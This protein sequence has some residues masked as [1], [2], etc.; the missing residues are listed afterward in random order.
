[1]VELQVNGQIMGFDDVVTLPCP[2]MLPAPT[3][4]LAGQSRL[5]QNCCSGFIGFLRLLLS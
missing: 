3:F 4:P 1:V 2:P 5:G